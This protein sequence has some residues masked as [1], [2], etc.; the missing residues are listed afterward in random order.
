M[1][2]I[3]I[4]FFLNRLHE[5]LTKSRHSALIEKF[6]KQSSYEFNASLKNCFKNMT[7]I[8]KPKFK[9]SQFLEIDSCSAPMYRGL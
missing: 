9:F 4:F 2:I 6:S 1:V 3:C 7:F 8:F 5:I